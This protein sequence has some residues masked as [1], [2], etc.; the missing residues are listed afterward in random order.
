MSTN[1]IA[2]GRCSIC[3]ERDVDNDKLLFKVEVCGEKTVAGFFDDVDVAVESFA[4][5]VELDEDSNFVMNNLLLFKA[6]SFV[7]DDE[8]KLIKKILKSF[9]RVEQ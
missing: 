1:K 6:K 2:C 5:N 9:V 7:G 8:K 3:I 4:S